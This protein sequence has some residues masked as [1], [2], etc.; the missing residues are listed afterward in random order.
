VRNTMVALAKIGLLL[1]VQFPNKGRKAVGVGVDAKA[2]EPVDGGWEPFPSQAHLAGR[3]PEPVPAGNLRVTPVR[4]G[5]LPAVTVVDDGRA[6]T[7]VG[8]WQGAI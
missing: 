3:L 8:G 5:D 1:E 2:V 4:V 6:V 7:D